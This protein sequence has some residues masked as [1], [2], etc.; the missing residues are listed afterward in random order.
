MLRIQRKYAIIPSTLSKHIKQGLSDTDKIF[1]LINSEANG[2]E[3]FRI[4]GEYTTN[5][6]YDAL[7]LSFSGLGRV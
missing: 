7:Y 3:S 2:S 6:K 5:S 4:I 1:Y